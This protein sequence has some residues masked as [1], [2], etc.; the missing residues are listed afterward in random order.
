MDAFLAADNQTLLRRTR[1]RWPSDRFGE[2]VVALLHQE[3]ELQRAMRALLQRATG[4]DQ[5]DWQ[6][7]LRYHLTQIQL[8]IA[9]LQALCWRLPFP[10]RSAAVKPG[11]A[12]LSGA[13]REGAGS[14]AELQ[15]VAE[16]H[17]R[18]K[19]GIGRLIE[20]EQVPQRDVAILGETAESHEEMS[21]MLNRLTCV[22]EPMA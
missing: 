11:V 19:T 17:L 14:I 13:R 10:R 9:V 18:L 12:V 20:D 16:L 22:N 8:T 7:I 3:I 21:W 5:D 6:E 4:T 2:G 15:A 1:S